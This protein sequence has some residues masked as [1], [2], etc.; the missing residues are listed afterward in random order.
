MSRATTNPWK[1][2]PSA[3]VPPAHVSAST[4][5]WPGY[6]AAVAGKPARETLLWALDAFEREGVP[7]ASDG[8]D[9]PLAVDLGCGE[10]RDTAELL[11][12]GWRVLAIDGHPMA[13]ELVNSRPNL[14]NRERLRVRLAPFEGLRLPGGLPLRMINASFSLPFCPPEHFEALWRTIVNALPPGGR[15]AGQL[16]GDRDE[17]ATLTDRSH[18]T[19]ERVDELLSPFDVEHFQEEERDGADAENNP[20]HWHVFHVVARKR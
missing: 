18:Q 10:G 6:F 11:A 4:R 2:L 1:D 5:N 20:K 16:F 9:A 15:F 14:A 13:V 17:W 12:R 8:K 19:R 3:G 7:D